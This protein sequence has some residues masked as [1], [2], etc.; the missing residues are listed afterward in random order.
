L[1]QIVEDDENLRVQ[2]TIT[3]D[4]ILIGFWRLAST[5]PSETTGSTR[6][7]K[8]A[9]RQL[10]QIADGFG[11]IA[12]RPRTELEELGRLGICSPNLSAILREIAGVELQ[13]RRKLR[14]I[15]GLELEIQRLL[16]QAAEPSDPYG[17]GRA[18]EPTK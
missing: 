17:R 14:E 1:S 3:A 2:M 6:I 10:L 5:P 18:G 11:F 12:C 7:Q 4:D 13:R 8:S 9:F 15:S 16:R